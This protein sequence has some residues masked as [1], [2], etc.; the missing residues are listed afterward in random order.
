MT[1]FVIFINQCLPVIVSIHVPGMIITVVLHLK[2]VE[3]PLLV[4]LGIH[5]I[6]R[7][8]WVFGS[9]EVY[10]NETLPVNMQ[11]KTEKRVEDLI[12]AF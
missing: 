8:R 2:V 10:P 3:S 7:A 11:V 1:H 4:D 6:P 5:L 12:K 9:V